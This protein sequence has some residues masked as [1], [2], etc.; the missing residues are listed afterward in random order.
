MRPCVGWQALIAATLLWTTGASGQMPLKIEPE[1]FGQA[2]F[3]MSPAEVER[4]YPRLT[5]LGRE[6]LG[7]TP[8]LSPLAVRQLLP[9]QELQG[10]SK[11]VRVELRYW[12]DRLWTVIVYYGDNSAEDVITVLRKQVGDPGNRDK[13]PTWRGEKVTVITAN[14]ER[15]YAI[16]DDALSREVQAVVFEA[17]GHPAPPPPGGKEKPAASGHAGTAPPP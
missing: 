14:R 9:P 5:T 16:S 13:E 1:G 12:K 6:N 4:L 10:L 7:A 8:V 15:W 2:R 11:P 17:L 3:G